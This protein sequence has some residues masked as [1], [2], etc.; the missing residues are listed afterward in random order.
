MTKVELE[1]IRKLGLD[2]KDFQP[3]AM[4]DEERLNE[5]EAVLLEILEI[6]GGDGV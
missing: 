6:I 3:R 4:T 1:M 5:Q 2:V